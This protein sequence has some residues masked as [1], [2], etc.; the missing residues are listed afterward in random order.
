MA[1][2]VQYE[3]IAPRRNLVTH[4]SELSCLF[5]GMKEVVV[6]RSFHR[7]KG[8]KKR[9]KLTQHK[10]SGSKRPE[11]LN[12]KLTVHEHT[13]KWNPQVCLS[14][15]RN[16]SSKRGLKEFWGLAEQNKQTETVDFSV[17]DNAHSSR[18]V[19]HAQIIQLKVWRSTNLMQTTKWFNW[20]FYSSLGLLKSPSS[21]R[22]CCLSLPSCQ[23]LSL[24]DRLNESKMLLFKCKIYYIYNI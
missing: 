9:M 22:V 16:R 23:H 1:V 11:N 7:K 12:P 4:Q 18:E 3:E 21:Q 13:C 10:S 24:K 6:V 20:Y 19:K 17:S 2:I 8:G 15:K 14:V 5:L